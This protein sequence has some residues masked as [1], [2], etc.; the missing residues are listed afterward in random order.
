LEFEEPN[1]IFMSID[2]P[3]VGTVDSEGNVLVPVD[4][5]GRILP[6]FE[7]L[8]RSVQEPLNNNAM[9]STINTE[10]PPYGPPTARPGSNADAGSPGEGEMG[11]DQNELDKAD[12]NLPPLG[13][14]TDSRE[15]DVVDDAPVK[16]NL[17]ELLSLANNAGGS[18]SDVDESVDADDVLDEVL[19]L[20]S[21][22]VEL[23]EQHKPS[24]ASEDWPNNP[25]IRVSQNE[26]LEETR[27]K[28]SSDEIAPDDFIRTRTEQKIE[29]V[30]KELPSDSDDV[31]DESETDLIF[32][33]KGDVLHLD[34]SLAR[35][36][37]ASTS[38]IFSLVS[39]VVFCHYALAHLI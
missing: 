31:G 1:D 20:A 30:A 37:G 2:D 11:Y 16:D 6:G 25:S 23:K 18:N 27:L 24:P 17:T 15:N 14:Y 10:A 13:D 5:D 28:Q 38:T 22:N 34:E 26:A 4:E 29:E 39:S 12:S 36:D 19:E 32:V 8:L 35:P 21:D 7:H 9:A 3:R 33:R